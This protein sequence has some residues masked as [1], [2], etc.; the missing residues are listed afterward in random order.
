MNDPAGL[1]NKSHMICPKTIDR[2]VILSIQKF[3]N[4]VLLISSIRHSTVD[5]IIGPGGMYG[6]EWQLRHSPGLQR[7]IQSKNLRLHS[8]LVDITIDGLA[9]WLSVQEFLTS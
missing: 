5:I 1:D 2:P 8:S 6:Q 4:D 9:K 3:I 7:G